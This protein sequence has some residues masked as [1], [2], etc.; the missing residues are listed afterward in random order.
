[1][2]NLIQSNKS[3]DSS[4][5][6]SDRLFIKLKPTLNP[7]VKLFFSFFCHQFANYKSNQK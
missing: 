6:D 3:F 1:M 4:A 2:I 5:V 7:F